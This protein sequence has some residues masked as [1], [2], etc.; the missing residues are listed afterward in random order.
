[1]EFIKEVAPWLLAAATGGVPALATLA[2][3]KVSDI[4]QEDVTPSQVQEK[5][6][7]ATFEQLQAAKQA[8]AEIALRA[9]ELG[10][11]NVE[12]LI[13]AE[14]SDK[15]SARKMQIAALQQDSWLAKNFVYM[16]ATFWTIATIIYIAFIT[17]GS[18][19]QENVRFADTILGFLLGTVIATIINFFMGTSF[20]SR[21][22]DDTIKELSK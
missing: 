6:G 4:F 22:K 1:M 20:T 8:D 13:N 16:L 5:L 21:L 15:D 7:S 12:M 18:I 9:Q 2:A 10:F 11:K 17:F 3:K 14:V 19:P